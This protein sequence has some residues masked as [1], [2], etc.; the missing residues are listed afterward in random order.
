MAM[1]EIAR[2]KLEHTIWED[3]SL[4]PEFFPSGD[5]PKR[6]RIM[7]ASFGVLKVKS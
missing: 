5:S 7:L 2:R 4:D 6:I 1:V 3:A